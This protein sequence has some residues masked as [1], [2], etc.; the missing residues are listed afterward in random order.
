LAGQRC[1]VS[2][3]IAEPEGGC[4]DA[5]ELSAMELAFFPAASRRAARVKQILQK[6]I[7]D[8]LIETPLLTY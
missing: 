2:E 1:A 3:H 4:P 7:F 5:N 8:L 6:D